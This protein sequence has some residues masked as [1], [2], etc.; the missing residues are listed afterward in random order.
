MH[1]D[2]LDKQAQA[3]NVFKQLWRQNPM[4]YLRYYGYDS[5]QRTYD[6]IT[7]VDTQMRQDAKGMKAQLRESLHQARMAMKNREYPKVMYYAW[8]VVEGLKKIFDPVEDLE[9]LRKDMLAEYYDQQGLSTEELSDMHEALRKQ[10][11]VPD[12]TEQG[13]TVT[14]ADLRRLLYTTAAPDPEL[15]TQAHLISEAGP[16]EWLKENIPTYRQM[17]GAMLDKIFRNRMGK[18]KEAA[19]KALRMAERSFNTM[20]DVFRQLDTHRTDF[21]AYLDTAKRFQSRIDTLKQE[22]SGMYQE[23]FSQTI[24]EMIQS[25]EA[26]ET[27]PPASTD[28]GSEV[29]EDTEGSG[30]AG[31]GTEGTEGTEGA[32]GIEET[33][34]VGT[35]GVG[36]EAA[37]G[38][39]EVVD[40]ELADQPGVPNAK[41]CDT[42]LRINPLNA[43]KCDKC[44][45]GDLKPYIATQKAGPANISAD[46]PEGAADFSMTEPVEE[47]ASEAAKSA[48]YVAHLAKRARYEADRGNHGIAGALLVRASEIC[49]HYDDDFSADQFLKAAERMLQG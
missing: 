28:E 37:G 40:R 6:E 38:A 8:Q 24:N 10:E 23:H 46:M 14:S 4:E 19:R 44:G 48:K 21:S 49:D 29:V 26:G 7:R 45:G 35:E 12:Q 13:Q 41:W 43:E 17:E 27:A 20:K 34:G 11:T 3:R 32:E 39:E 25:P 22:L 18:Q 16:L 30:T 9:K 1:M 5:Y 33:E 36:D 47:Q 31:E 15:V 2:G 42:C